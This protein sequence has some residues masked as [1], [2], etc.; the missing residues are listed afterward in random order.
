[1]QFYHLTEDDR[2]RTISE[3]ERIVSLERERDKERHERLMQQEE[4]R[5]NYHH[6]SQ[7]QLV[8]TI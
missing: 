7:P 3:H 6:H 4:Q 2:I 5:Y 1:M 8:G